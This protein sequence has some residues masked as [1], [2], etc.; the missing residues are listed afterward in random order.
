MKKPVRSD[1]DIDVSAAQRAQRR[2]LLS[3]RFEARHVGNLYRKAAHTRRNRRIMLHRENRRR[4]QDRHLL[5]AQYRLESRAQCD[6]GF[7]EADVPA[8][9]T[10]HRNR[11][12]HIP[13]NVGGG[14]ELRVR[15]LIFK[16]GFKFALHLVVRRK[17]ESRT[18]Q[19]LRIKRDELLGHAFDFA[20][21]AGLRFR[22]FGAAKP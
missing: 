11:L 19:A 14:D 8:K 4:H 7:A 18:A 17:G 13:L 5:G 2:V 1:D 9:Q 3:G 15:L 6:L 22:P 21:H 10:V 12:F 20:F 16:H